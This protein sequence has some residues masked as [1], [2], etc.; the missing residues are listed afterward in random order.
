MEEM[1]REIVKSDSNITV[2]SGYDF[3]PKEEQY[4]ADKRLHPN[5]SGF[6]Y[7]FQNLKKSIV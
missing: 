5:D 4:F 7:Y 6:E 1:I 3:I 2:I